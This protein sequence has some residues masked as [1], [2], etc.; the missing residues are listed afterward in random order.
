MSC[1]ICGGIGL[2]PFIKNGKVIPNTFLFCECHEEKYESYREPRPEDFDFPMSYSVYRSLCQQHGWQD[3]GPD[4][5][6]E[7]EEQ[8]RPYIPRPI[9]NVTYQVNSIQ[10]PAFQDLEDKIRLINGRLTKYFEGKKKPQ[11]VK[12]NKRGIKID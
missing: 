9:V 11:P 5:P 1:F 2:V 6:A 4:R 8:Q 12:S 10:T 7:P 3:P